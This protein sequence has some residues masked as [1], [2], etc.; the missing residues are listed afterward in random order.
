METAVTSAT[1]KASFKDELSFIKTPRRAIR[2]RDAK[3]AEKEAAGLSA[4]VDAVA[5]LIR[6]C[7]DTVKVIAPRRPLVEDVAASA[8]TFATTFDRP[9]EESLAAATYFGMIP[10]GVLAEIGHWGMAERSR[11]SSCTCANGYAAVILALAQAAA[12]AVSD[13]W[14]VAAID[15][16]FEKIK[17]SISEPGET[18]DPRLKAITAAIHQITKAAGLPVPYFAVPQNAEG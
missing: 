16:H 14:T 17:A 10:P 9:Y 13:Q 7:R 1:Q 5:I 11:C 4:S 8:R 12:A 6:R 18:N 3:A 2:V 15:Q